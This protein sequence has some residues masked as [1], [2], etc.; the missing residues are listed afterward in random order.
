MKTRSLVLLTL[1]VVLLIGCMNNPSCVSA[2]ISDEHARVNA[3]LAPKAFPE[4]MKDSLWTWSERENVR[5][6]NV[7]ADSGFSMDC[8]VCMTWTKEGTD[9]QGL[10]NI[11]VSLQRLDTVIKSRT[12]STYTWEM[13]VGGLNPRYVY[14]IPKMF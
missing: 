10:W 14:I 6:D 11:G 13:A 2:N 7:P 3:I 1:T 12:G 9:A 8:A 4:W 5:I